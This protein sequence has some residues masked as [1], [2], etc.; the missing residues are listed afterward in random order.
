[1]PNSSG[2]L[3]VG[4]TLPR[5]STT[6]DRRR[7]VAPAEQ[8]DPVRGVVDRPEVIGTGAD[9]RGE[10]RPRV[11]VA[12]PQPNA[13]DAVGE[14]E[15]AR[16]GKVGDRRRDLDRRRRHVGQGAPGLRLGVERHDRR[17]VV[18]PVK[19]LAASGIDRIV[20]VGM[21]DPVPRGL[22][23]L[24]PRVGSFDEP[25]L[26]PARVVPLADESNLA[27]LRIPDPLVRPLEDRV[28]A[29][30]RVDQIVAVAL[31]GELHPRTGLEGLRRVSE[32]AGRRRS[33]QTRKRHRD[34]PQ[35]RSSHARSV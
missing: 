23:R 22:G 5:A 25:D 24:V 15:P 28:R 8:H 3:A 20:L 14:H 33:R 17:R 10:L 34:Q 29:V 18:V 1:M 19:A 4:V 32:L 30:A 7:T 12:R 35:L 16:L 11:R 13:G 9:L 2:E 27:P 26:F 31:R 6:V 21:S